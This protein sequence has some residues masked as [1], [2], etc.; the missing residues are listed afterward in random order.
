MQFVRSVTHIFYIELKLVADNVEHIA[1]KS[2]YTHLIDFLL[3]QEC[4]FSDLSFVQL[5]F[6]NILETLPELAAFEQRQTAMIIKSLLYFHEPSLST[7]FSLRLCGEIGYPLISSLTFS[8]APQQALSPIQVA[9]RNHI[10]F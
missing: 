8:A 10:L 9:F 2:S 3:D 1:M 6:C 7:D 5:T 4:T